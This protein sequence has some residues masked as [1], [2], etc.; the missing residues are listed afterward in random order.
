V[1][2]SATILAG[3]VALTAGIAAT[4]QVGVNSELQKW[5]G[6]SVRA[7]LVSLALG[8]LVLLLVSAFAGFAWPLRESVSHAPWWAWTGGALGALYLVSTVALAHRLGASVLFA[9]VIAGQLVAAVVFDHFGFI[10]FAVHHVSAGRVAGV[11]LLVTGVVLI[12]IY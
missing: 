9:L 8:T 12:R 3:S 1:S 6:T 11:V 5:V 2:Y 4:S 10:G 7:A